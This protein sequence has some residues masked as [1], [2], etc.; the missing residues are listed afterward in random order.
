[1]TLVAFFTVHRN[2]LAIAHFD[3]RLFFINQLLKKIQFCGHVISLNPLL[4]LTVVN[5]RS[6]TQLSASTGQ[7]K[8]S[9]TKCAKS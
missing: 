8:G 7:S 3:I 1:M 5:M 9:Q 4:S 2:V 6:F